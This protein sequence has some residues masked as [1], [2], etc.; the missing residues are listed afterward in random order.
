MKT[1][2]FLDTVRP[3]SANA[4]DVIVQ[5]SPEASAIII[6]YPGYKGDINGYNN[7]YGALGEDLS[8]KG[9]GAFIQMPNIVWPNED[10]QSSLIADLLDVC[11]Y[12]RAKAPQIC[13][14]RTP[15]ILLMG[16]SA[17]GSA[18]AGAAL[19]SGAKKILLLAPSGDAA[20]DEVTTSLAKYTGEVF[21]A[22]GADDSVVGGAKTGKAYLDMAKSASRKKLVVIP[23]CDHQ[24]RG[25]ENGKIMSKAPLWAFAGDTTFPS[26]DGGLILY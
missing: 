1:K 20:E 23:H 7:K 15:D 24:F 19:R 10:Y 8:G 14:S 21:I 22:I 9:I 26:P 25:T 17:G 11:E 18:V 13:K 2:P 3:G 16:F 5:P 6:N 4:F 12:A